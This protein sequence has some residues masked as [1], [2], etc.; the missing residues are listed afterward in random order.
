MH[1]LSPL[2]YHLVNVLLHSLVC[3]IFYKICQKLTSNQISQNASLLFA[4]H[5][6]HTEAVTGIVG[7][8]E[9]LS[10][11]FFLLSIWIHLSQKL[12]KNELVKLF[13]SMFFACCAMFCKEQ[14]ITVLG[15]LAIYEIFVKKQ[16]NL[17]LLAVKILAFVLTGVALL[18]SRF[19]V[20]GQTLPVFTNFDNP[21]SYA[22]FPTKQLTWAYLLP[23]KLIFFL[24]KNY[25][26]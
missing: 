8:A 25:V 16:T 7:R 20:M 11:L 1:D 18:A 12:V 22:D 3:L 14:G 23:G 24:K 17:T 19:L 10:S 26:L 5:P 21:A 4:L 15:I 2:G 6:I 9:L 13:L